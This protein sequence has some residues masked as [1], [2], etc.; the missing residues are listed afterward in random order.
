MVLDRT[1]GKGGDEARAA[2]RVRREGSERQSE[3]RASVE[4]Q[5]RALAAQCKRHGWQ[6]LEALE[7]AGLS[8][9]DLQAGMQDAQRVRERADAQA[10]VAAERDATRRPPSDRAGEVD[11]DVSTVRG[12]MARAVGWRELRISR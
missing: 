3:R 6:L 12:L 4:A 11:G 10:L 7:D 2:P 9:K 1:P 8:A 5:R